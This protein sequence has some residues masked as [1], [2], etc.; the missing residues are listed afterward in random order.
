[1]ANFA[2]EASD[3]LRGASPIEIV[4]GLISGEVKYVSPGAK[5]VWGSAI[6]ELHAGALPQTL[7]FSRNDSSL[8]VALAKRRELFGVLLAP[9]MAEMLFT[10]LQKQRA[11]VTSSLNVWGLIMLPAYSAGVSHVQPLA[12]VTMDLAPVDR[13]EQTQPHDFPS[14]VSNLFPQAQ[15]IETADI[16]RQD[17][18]LHVE[19]QLLPQPV[20]QQASG[21]QQSQLQPPPPARPQPQLQE[22]AQPQS[23]DP[24][25]LEYDT[26]RP[27]RDSAS[28]GQQSSMSRHRTLRPPQLLFANASSS[29]QPLFVSEEQPY[30][31]EEEQPYFMADMLQLQT[32]TYSLR[33]G[34][35][36]STILMPRHADIAGSG[37]LQNASV[38]NELLDSA[39]SLHRFS[40]SMLLEGGGMRAEGVGGAR[41]AAG[42]DQG[43]QSRGGVGRRDGHRS[44]LRRV[45]SR[46]LQD[47]GSSAAAHQRVILYDSARVQRSDGSGGATAAAA[48]IEEHGAVGSGGPVTAP[49]PLSDPDATD[50]GPIGEF[51]FSVPSQTLGRA[52]LSEMSSQASQLLSPIS[53]SQLLDEEQR[54]QP[55]PSSHNAVGLAVAVAAAEGETATRAPHPTTEDLAAAAPSTVGTVGEEVTSAALYADP[56]VSPFMSSSGNALQGQQVQQQLQS[57][58]STSGIAPG[59][60]SSNPASNTP[61]RKMNTRSR[62]D[63]LLR[64]C[65]P[66]F[67]AKMRHGHRRLNDSTRSSPGMVS[68]SQSGE[69]EEAPLPRS[70]AAGV[71]REVH[72]QAP[73]SSSSSGLEVDL[74]GRGEDKDVLEDE[75]DGLG[76]GRE[77]EE[78][79]QAREDNGEGEQ[80]IHEDGQEDA[81]TRAGR[82]GRWHQVRLQLIIPREGDDAM[83][84]AQSWP[85]GAAEAPAATTD[86]S[87]V[88]AANS[89]DGGYS[90][91]PGQEPLLR[92][93][94]TDVDELVRATLDVAA[95]LLRFQSR[96]TELEA[97]LASE[98]KLLEAVFPR[99]AI[100]HMTRVITARSSGCPPDPPMLTGSVAMLDSVC[101]PVIAGLKFP[102]TA[103][104]ALD[105]TQACALPNATTGGRSEARL[106]A[107]WPQ[108]ERSL[109]NQSPL[110]AGGGE[111]SDGRAIVLPQGAAACSE[112]ESR[113]NGPQLRRLQGPHGLLRNTKAKGPATKTINSGACDGASAGWPL[114]PLRGGSGTSSCGGNGARGR[115]SGGTDGGGGSSGPSTVV[116]PYSSGAPSNL[117]GSVPLAT[118]H[119]CVTVLFADIVGFTTMCNCLEPL[120]VMNFLNELYTRFDSL[121]DIYGVYKVET[122]GD[123]FMAVGGLI[124]V[125]GEGFKAVR[126]DGSEDG[127]H[128][129]KVMSFAKAMLRE[130]AALVMPHNGSPLRLRVGLH[131]GPITAG[132]VGSKMPRFCLFGDT[133]NTASRMESTCE[134]GAIHVSAATRELLPEEHWVATGGV[135]VKGKGEMQTFLWR[136]PPGFAAPKGAFS[137]SVAALG[138]TE[139][140]SGTATSSSGV[141]TPGRPGGV[142]GPLAR[143]AISDGE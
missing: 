98:H 37:R 96:Y 32:H 114:T 6:R 58:S 2:L 108:L 13:P 15:S 85:A 141:F 121:C 130:V 143:A 45:S 16:L 17:P 56:E 38:R 99:Q 102:R 41:L 132:I 89:T 43:E 11:S 28:A 126:G 112:C 62:L 75:D 71:A 116:R 36:S 110:D 82:E 134:P 140:A 12:E 46:R 26:G 122:I 117:D 142:T 64:S 39:G 77:E 25:E 48:V 131:S 78:E 67:V 35:A 118:A 3:L 5:V 24:T 125:D 91:A 133:V 29:R 103:A 92:M 22:P 107:T 53:M 86:A 42:G 90:S 87:S 50:A 105:N 106:P 27:L 52:S 61:I 1:M 7:C 73:G 40:G 88:A 10:S 100:E 84:A 129:L 59:P 76:E 137:A 139:W 63:T 119:R 128:A 83:T 135:Q 60:S 34:A 65:N 21:Q 49:G 120:E 81:M 9:E 111:V 47:A 14:S 136:P 80:E 55:R 138:H 79:E 74:S 44:R 104:G 20:E 33:E 57:G 68:P 72:P 101:F 113:H 30:F 8:H 109:F 18:V 54:Q 94:L 70:V 51:D 97:L 93:V 31:M 124:T 127:L 115:D 69:D 95:E 23:V 123:C 4:I 19:P 66:A